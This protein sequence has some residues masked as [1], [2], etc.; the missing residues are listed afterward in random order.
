MSSVD[1]W[2]KVENFV[3]KIVLLIFHNDFLFS[4]GVVEKL[5]IKLWFKRI[6]VRSSIGVWSAQV[7]KLTWLT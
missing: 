6:G 4:V 3:Q 1:Y 5:W 2:A 7:T